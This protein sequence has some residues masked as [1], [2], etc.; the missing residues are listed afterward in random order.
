MNL[1]R[2][3]LMDVADLMAAAEFGYRPVVKPKT[4]Y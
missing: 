2:L 4:C 1:K 3:L